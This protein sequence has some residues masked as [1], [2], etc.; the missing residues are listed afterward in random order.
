M[1]RIIPLEQASP[2]QRNE[3]A[4]LLVEA[5]REMAPEA[6]PTVEAAAAEVA[7]S[8]GP[9]RI[10]LIA[11][12]DNERVTGWIGGISGYDGRVWELHPLAVRPDV[13]R[14]GIGSA[15]VRRL[16]DE[17]RGRGCLTLWLGTDDIAGMTSLVGEDLY[18]DPLLKLAAIRNPGRHPYEFYQRLGY[19]L[20]GV[21]PDANG[22]GKPDIL[23]AKRV[24]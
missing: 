16:E 3:T 21:V 23:M 11:I 9:E 24:Q 19:A 5:F 20:A 6:W 4:E 14:R 15:L 2:D 10:S 22:F 18:P 13:Q 1:I 17:V 7:E 12:D 8:V